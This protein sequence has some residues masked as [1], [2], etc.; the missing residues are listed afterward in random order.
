MVPVALKEKEEWRERCSRG[1]VGFALT[2]F[3]LIPRII[4]PAFEWELQA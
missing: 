4:N 1:K 2:L 3:F